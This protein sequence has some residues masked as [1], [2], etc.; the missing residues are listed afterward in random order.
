MSVNVVGVRARKARLIPFYFGIFMPFLLAGYALFGRGFAYLGI[1]PLFICEFGVVFAVAAVF[2]GFNGL[3]WR[4]PITWLLIAFSLW[5][6]AQTLPYISDYG[7]TA[8]RDAVIWGY[9]I[10]ALAIASVVLTFNAVAKVVHWYRSAVP[11]FLLVS[12]IVLVIQFLFREFIPTWPWGPLDAIGAGSGIPIIDVKM[13]DL[14]VHLAGILAFVVLGVSTKPLSLPWYFLWAIIVVVPSLLS[15][16][17]F[18]A[19]GLV[20]WTAAFLRPTRKYFYI[21]L[22]IGGGLIGG[23]LTGVEVDPGVSSG[24][25]VSVQQLLSNVESIVSSNNTQDLEANKVWRQLWWERILNYTFFGEYFWTGKGFGINLADADGG[26]AGGDRSLRSP[27]SV[28]MTVL[29]RTG[30]PGFALWVVLQTT[31]GLML[32]FKLLKDRR[33]GREKLARIEAWIFLYWLAFLIN[34]SFDVAVEGPQG[35]IWFWS[36]FGFGLALIVSPDKSAR[37]PAQGS[38]TGTPRGLP[39]Q[40]KRASA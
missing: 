7:L 29:A 39:T 4:S 16:G 36:V 34:A 6:A 10:F 9:V 31:F 25:V 8:L 37:L 20:M 22:F 26:F 40:T 15:R 30:V 1:P 21:L 18:L 35:G 12:A 38:Q 33:F 23:Y 14:A 28:H 27:H 3:L 2:L 13:G 11:V 17:A 24:R 19:I 5:G 32:F